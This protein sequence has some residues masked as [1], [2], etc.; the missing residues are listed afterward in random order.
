[1]TDRR[2]KVTVWYYH[3]SKEVYRNQTDKEAT[4]WEQKYTKE[5]TIIKGVRVENETRL[6]SVK[7]A[8]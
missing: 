8:E 6:E 1:M 3:R 4:A 5:R 7:D 2:F